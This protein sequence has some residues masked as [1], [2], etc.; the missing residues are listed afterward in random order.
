[1][2]NRTGL[3]IRVAVP[4]LLWAVWAGA[5]H[6]S[7]VRKH[8]SPKVSA[9]ILAAQQAIVRADMPG[10]FYEKAYRHAEPFYWWQIP[11]WM[12]QDA[13]HRR[14]RRILDIGC[15]YGTLLSVATAIY[16]SNGY[17]MDV[18]PYLLPPVAARKSLQFSRGNIELDPIPW[19][20]GFDVII[21]TE[22]LE[23]FNFQ[24]VPTLRKIREALAP[25]GLLFLSTPDAQD[26]GRTEQ[27]YRPLQDIPMPSAGAAIV[28][29]HIWQYSE[30][31]L[32]RV[33]KAA[34]F[35]VVRWDHA[36]GSGLRHFNVVAKRSL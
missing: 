11:P 6:E 26:W 35:E 32:R 13:T 14:V 1:M 18:T 28:D 12:E 15:G 8:F 16:G 30:E 19:A 29:D 21:M 17:C 3:A 31:E 36:P 7:Q 10:G 4:V 9:E 5:D 20:G 25:D 23:H 2:S 24:P 27:Y 22:V 34:G 33:L